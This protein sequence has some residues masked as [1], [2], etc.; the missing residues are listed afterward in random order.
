[1]LTYHSKEGRTE[2]C[3]VN[4]RY[5]PLLLQLTDENKRKVLGDVLYLIRFPTMD[6]KDFCKNVGTSRVLTAEENLDIVL[7]LNELTPHNKINFPRE[8]RLGTEQEHFFTN[9]CYHDQHNTYTTSFQQTVLLN[10]AKGQISISS[11]YLMG[12]TEGQFSVHVSTRNGNVRKVENRLHQGYQL[13][14]AVFDP[15]VRIKSGNHDIQFRSL[16]GSSIYV[17][18]V[19]GQNTIQ[20]KDVTFSMASNPWCFVVGFKFRK[21]L[22]S[23]CQSVRGFELGMKKTSNTQ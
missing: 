20:H 2:E 8:P 23:F 21:C 16:P 13:Y 7:H 4:N 14:E 12:V 5:C 19:Q 10:I 11:V 17:T 9:A 3:D 6:D 22:N 18:R 1:M 15:P